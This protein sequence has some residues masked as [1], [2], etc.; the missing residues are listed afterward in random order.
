MS[1]HLV[2]AIC[3]SAY[4]HFRSINLDAGVNYGFPFNAQVQWNGIPVVGD[5]YAAQNN[6][7][8]NETMGVVDSKTFTFANPNVVF[9]ASASGTDLAGRPE[10]TPIVKVSGS[11]VST[12]FQ[13]V[14][15]AAGVQQVVFAANPAAT[16]TVSYV[17]KQENVYLL[18][19]NKADL[20][21]PSR[22]RSRSTPTC[23]PR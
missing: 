18:S 5:P 13:F 11:I 20:V 2:T 16:P 23:S 4:N 1:P 22:C 10:T 3:A 7:V 19:R 17:W 12:G 6:S 14:T 15:T 9:Y 8:T 21:L